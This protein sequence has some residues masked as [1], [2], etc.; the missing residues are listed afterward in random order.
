MKQNMLKLLNFT[1][2]TESDTDAIQHPLLPEAYF[3]E[4][5]RAFRAVVL[6]FLGSSHSIFYIIS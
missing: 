1:F 3:G 6:R 4:I 5:W 2:D